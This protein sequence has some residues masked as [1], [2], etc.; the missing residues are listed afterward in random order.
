[1][2]Q[3]IEAHGSGYRG[4]RRDPEREDVLGLLLD[5]DRAMQTSWSL[6]DVPGRKGA[7]PGGIISV[8]VGS[9][10]TGR[11][12]D[13]LIVD[14]PI[15]DAHQADSTVYRQRVKDWFQSVANTRIAGRNIIIV[16]Q[17]RWHEDDLTGWL[18]A[19]DDAAV[20]PQ[21]RR[22]NIRAQAEDDDPLGRAPGE[23]LISARGR[24]TEEWEQKKIDVGTRWWY[25]LYQGRPSPPGG[26]IF[27]MAWF[28]KHRVAF[29]PELVYV[30]TY[31]DP[32]DN[33]GGGDE[34]GICTAGLG[35]DGNVY[36]LADDSGTYTVAGWV[37]A[38]VFAL[39]SNDGSRL[40]Y[41][42]SLSGLKRSIIAEWKMIRREATAL[43]EAHIHG[44]RWRPTYWP[45]EADPLAIE[46]AHAALVMD[47]DTPEERAELQRRLLAIW[48]YVPRVLDTPRTGPPTRRITARGSKSL[49]ADMVSPL[50]EN[51]VARMVG[52][53]PAAEHQMV[54]WQPTQ[55][56]PDRMDAIVHAVTDL[57][58]NRG[59]TVE[60]PTTERQLPGR[61]RAMPQILRTTRRPL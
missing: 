5:P 47:D 44:G 54:T 27:Q 32:A 22:L 45:P 39:L 21:Y 41:E 50:F 13:V 43:R 58:K 30:A 9:A 20:T 34:A 17:T 29:R 48:P 14:D 52:H 37:R 42:Q 19:E 3:M 31:V 25:A 16:I 56:S 53:H 18:I 8:G 4:Q 1:V 51:G 33:D 57:S 7:R 60:K 38:A 49:R 40:C 12:L 55:D 24:S 36:I 26:K 11:P 2:R 35:A 61:Q 10:L 15:K 59:V 23:Y 6:A 28:D 46:D